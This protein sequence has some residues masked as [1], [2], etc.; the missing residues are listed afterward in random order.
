MDR[1]SRAGERARAARLRGSRD[2]PPGTPRVVWMG[3]LVALVAMTLWASSVVLGRLTEVPAVLHAS[4]ILFHEAG[5]VLF[6]PFGEVP[7]VAGG[8]LVQLGVPAAC[9]VS[10]FRRGDRF[11]AALC[12]AWTG[13]SLVDAAVYAYDAADPQLPLIGGGTGAD[14]FHDFVFLFDRFGRLEQARGWARGMKTLG[15]LG[16]GASLTWAGIV[17][18]RQ[19]GTLTE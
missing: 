8:T 17:L 7:G 19:R 14:A 13:L 3:R 5:H 16:A 18:R 4:V 1:R 15:A 12:L 6:G 10:L 2:L 11:G 9:A